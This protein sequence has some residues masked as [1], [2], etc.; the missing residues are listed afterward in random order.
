MGRCHITR[1]SKVAF[2]AAKRKKCNVLVRKSPSVS[3]LKGTMGYGQSD[4]ELIPNYYSV[5]LTF[6][7]SFSCS[8]E[9][10]RSVISVMF[11]LF[12]YVH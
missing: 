7:Y 10:S 3:D 6:R 9:A 2:T 8:F 11:Y 12:F 4:F 1:F 5:T